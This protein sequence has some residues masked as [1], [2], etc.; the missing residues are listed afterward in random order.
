MKLRN[1]YKYLCKDRTSRR[2]NKTCEGMGEY[3]KDNYS[4]CLSTADSDFQFPKYITNDLMKFLKKG[5]LNYSFKHSA[6]VPL[7]NTWYK[8]H[9][10]GDN[11]HKEFNS[12]NVMAGN[13]VINFVQLSILSFSNEGEG[14]IFLAP[15]YY[16]FLT[17]INNAKRIPKRS[18]LI[19]N[20]EKKTF[21]IDF[22][23]LENLMKE[24]SNKI[25][26]LCNPHN[27]IGM[28]WN[29]QEIERIIALSRKYNVLIVSDEI[30]QDITFK[31]N[32]FTPIIYSMKDDDMIIS[33]SSF[34]KT[35][36]LG[37][38]QFGYGCSYNTAIIKRLLEEK[39][40]YV[41]Y[42][43][44]NLINIE[45]VRSCIENKNNELWLNEYKEYLYQNYLLFRDLIKDTDIIIPNIQG[46]YLCWM[47]FKNC[48]DIT[49]AKID[50]T[51]KSNGIFLEEGTDFCNDYEL[52]RRINLS[53]SKKHIIKIGNII[54]E[55]F[56]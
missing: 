28:V 41:T 50:K 46:T 34:A 24:K 30:W 14:V 39:N 2:Y 20:N 9:Y 7:I 21:E 10:N 12:D 44:D 33:T 26:L 37:G 48:K 55:C 17:S 3:C 1:N 15:S 53:I 25:L 5:D 36:N 56:A 42:A 31:G 23:D 22:E 52:C 18:E 29:K 40:K 45:I 43:S 47:D 16:A 49:S 27:P 51:L 19:F 54:K 13:G 35:F 6:F 38:A 4:F 32:T 8:N 11:L